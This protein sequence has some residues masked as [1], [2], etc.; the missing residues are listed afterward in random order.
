[1]DRLAFP[2][3]VKLAADD[4]AEAMSFSG[5]GAVFG[6]T[7]SH[8]DVIAKGAF[9]RTL[10]EAKKTG[11]Y[12]I[13]L[14]QHGNWLGGDDNMPV[15]VW[16]SMEEDDHGLRV[17]GRLA[18]T[19]RGL[20]AYKLLKMSPRPALTGLSIGFLAKEFVLG[21]KPDEPRRTLKDVHLMEVSLVNW[22]SNPLARVT[23]VKAGDIGTPRD[24][25]RFLRDAGFSHA[26]AK[27]ITARG[28]KA[29]PDPR[30]EDGAN[31]WLDS[32][33]RRAAALAG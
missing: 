7:D 31:E 13:M 27:A 2:F 25:E 24:F 15:G 9:K 30:D 23:G 16:D 21:T 29:N 5:Y 8:G 18:D 32:M 28:F 12:P 1:M 14:L 6:N 19:T 26:A 22:P 11:A 20:D 33:K 10:R 4:D 17:E 3:E